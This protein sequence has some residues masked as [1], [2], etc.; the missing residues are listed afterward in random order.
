[1][2]TNSSHHEQ[3]DFE[4]NSHPVSQYSCLYTKQKT[5][6]KKVWQDGRI[7]IRGR[8]VELHY[9]DPPLGSGDQVIDCCKIG[10]SDL[11]QIISGKFHQVLEMEKCIVK[12]EGPWLGTKKL[13]LADN[14]SVQISASMKKV[15]HNKF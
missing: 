1:M 6:K 9:D 5:Q 14:E 13:P 15:I 2:L 3:N 4:T 7:C 10:G 12:V 8:I 11:Q